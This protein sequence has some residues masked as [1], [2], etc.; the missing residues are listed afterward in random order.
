M[1][2]DDCGDASPTSLWGGKKNLKTMC[3]LVRIGQVPGMILRAYDN[4]NI[5]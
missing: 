4:K 3:R 5:L 1:A 2:E